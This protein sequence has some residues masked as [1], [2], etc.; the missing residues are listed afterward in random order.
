MSSGHRHGAKL[1]IGVQD[2]ID[3][4]KRQALGAF[5]EIDNEGDWLHGAEACWR[6]RG[7][8]ILG[9]GEGSVLGVLELDLEDAILLSSQHIRQCASL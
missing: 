8:W 9:H 5:G 2:V 3:F 4:L 7:R 6:S 1:T